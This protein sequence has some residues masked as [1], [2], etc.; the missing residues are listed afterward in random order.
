MANLPDTIG[1][2]GAAVAADFR[3][4]FTAG[5]IVIAA[6]SYPWNDDAGVSVSA[7]TVNVLTSPVF[8]GILF[9][10]TYIVDALVEI[11][12]ETFLARIAGNYLW[13]FMVSLT[14]FSHVK[15]PFRYVLRSIFFLPG[16]VALSY[17]YLV[18]AFFGVSDFRLLQ[19]PRIFTAR[20]QRYFCTLPEFVRAGLQAPFGDNYEVAWRLLEND[21]GP[22]GV[23]WLRSLQERTRDVLAIVTALFFSNVIV[24]YVYRVGGNATEAVVSQIAMLILAYVYF[25]EL[26]RS[27]IAA[28][29]WVAIRQTVVEPDVQ[30]NNALEPTAHA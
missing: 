20:A 6:F 29:E 28:V 9:A 2:T 3:R 13:A 5:L 26:K 22:T 4:R 8:A 24:G 10:A 23:A 7:E 11:T 19:S 30:P 25:L 1:L 14:W 17:F 21:A 12:G 16:G 27:T 15:L 18:R